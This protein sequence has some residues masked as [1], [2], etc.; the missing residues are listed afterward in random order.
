MESR[1]ET[2]ETLATRRAE[3]A[4]PESKNKL[5]SQTQ[6]SACFI[7]PHSKIASAA[8]H[9]LHLARPLAVSDAK[10]STDLD[11]ELDTVEPL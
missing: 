10:P 11:P 8:V 3:S 5:P 6:S 2:I 9:F 7:S 4:T 1:F